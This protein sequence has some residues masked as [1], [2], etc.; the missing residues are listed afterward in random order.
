MSSPTS[1]TRSPRAIVDLA[2]E[3]SLVLTTGG[4]GFAPRDV[5]PEATLTV[6]DREAPGIAEAIRA[7]ALAK[8]PH[9][10]LSRGV[11][12]LRGSTLVVNLPGSPGG[13]RDGFAVLL[14]AL[15]HAPRARRG[16]PGVAPPSDVSTATTASLPRRLR[17]ARASSSTPSSRSRSPTSARSSP[18]TASPGWSDLLWISVAMVGARTLAMGLNRLVDAGID[19]RNPRTASRELP[20]GTLTPRQVW[21]AVR[22]ALAIYLVAVFQLDPI[23][24]WLWPI[25][26]ALFVLYPYLK[27]FT[28]LCHLW[29][30]V[31]TGLA[32]LGAWIAVTG[33]G[34][35]GGVGARRRPGSL[36]RR[37]RPLL[38]PLRPRARSP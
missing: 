10:L 1:G 37:L 32:P 26:V 4:T 8:T 22:A 3:A 19:A 20:A 34:P 16:R 6:I 30:G 13:C 35:V 17:D 7:D 11:A 29:L 12:G 18:S 38:R 33:R 9:A 14:P 27:R 21:R 28:W 31:C 2:A 5:T 25:P 23:V 15:A 36:G 24:R